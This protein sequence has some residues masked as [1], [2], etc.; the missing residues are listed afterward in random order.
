M[1]NFRRKND[2][3]W[4]IITIYK[5]HVTVSFERILCHNTY[6]FNCAYDHVVACFAALDNMGFYKIQSNDNRLVYASNRL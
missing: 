1:I 5:S 4:V 2:L 6:T 3:C